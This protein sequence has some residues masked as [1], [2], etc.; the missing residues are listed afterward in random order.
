[1]AIDEQRLDEAE[2]LFSESIALD[3]AFANQWGVAQNLSGQAVLAL[4]RGAPDEA[5]ALLAEAVQ[6]LR[7]LGDRLSLVMALERLAATAAAR[8]DHAFAAR[9]WGAATAHRE[10]AGEPLTAAEASAID[11]YSTSRARPSGPSASRRPQPAEP[12]SNSRRRSRKR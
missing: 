8:N 12:R 5:A 1:M 10:A 11:G 6:T 2:A 3:R 4:A 9:L 7:R